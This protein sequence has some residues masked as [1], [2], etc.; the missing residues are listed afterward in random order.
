MK[1]SSLGVKL[2]GLAAG[3]LLVGML[4]STASAVY[5]PPTGSVSMSTSSTTPAA[6]TSVSISTTVLNQFGSPAFSL[7]CTFQV[8]SQPGSDAVVDAGPKV[9]DDNGVASTTLNVGA[10]AGTIVVGANCGEMSGQVSVTVQGASG[11]PTLRLPPTGTGP[12]ETAPIWLI[13]L[14]TGLLCVVAGSSLRIAAR[15]AR[16]S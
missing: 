15:R 14:A 13:V 12:A 2:A 7:S 11:A 6:G 10:A 8:L 16:G 3:V 1:W 4:G 5:P 9:T